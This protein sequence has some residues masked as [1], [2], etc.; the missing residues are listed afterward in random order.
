MKKIESFKVNSFLLSLFICACFAGQWLNGFAFAGQ[1]TPVV[2]HAL[3]A[4]GQSLEKAKAEV[5]RL[6]DAWDKARLE[7]TLYDKRA[8][9]AYQRWVKA[10]KKSREAAR[11]A[12]EKAELEFQVAIEK[13]K[14]AWSEWQAALF[15]EAAKESRDKAL[16][17]DKETKAIRERI[18]KLQEKLPT[19]TDSSPARSKNL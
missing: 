13:R 16:D 7:A 8:K 14:L 6:R 4:A 19:P 3:D 17:Q 12:K 5:Q 1:E 10:V 18:K 11:L 9:R 2:D 15:R